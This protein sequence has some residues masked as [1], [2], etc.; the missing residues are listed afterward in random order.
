MAKKRNRP[1]KFTS[2]SSVP[3]RIHNILFFDSLARICELLC[4]AMGTLFYWS[5]LITHR[6]TCYHVYRGTTFSVGSWLLFWI[7]R[8][9]VSYYTCVTVLICVFQISL[10][11]PDV[12][13][14]LKTL[15]G[16]TIVSSINY[17]ATNT[18]WV[19]IFYEMVMK[20]WHCWVIIFYEMVMKKWH[21]LINE[22]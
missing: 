16:A 21:F 6:N 9:W 8:R 18:R 14:E 1:S 12:C 15:Y 4:Y 22:T 17:S 7:R 3:T 2:S 11:S 10:V 5:V 20:K 13:A 19:I